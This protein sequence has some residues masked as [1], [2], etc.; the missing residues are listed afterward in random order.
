MCMI[1]SVG[2]AYAVN[3]QVNDSDV[4]S[5]EK[6][7]VR[8]AMIE[9][10][11]LSARPKWKEQVTAQI[12]SN[13]ASVACIWSKSTDFGV[14]RMHS[15]NVTVEFW[16]G[17]NE[18]TRLELRVRPREDGAV[19]GEEPID[20]AG[21]LAISR[22][23]VD[24]QLDGYWQSGEA[25]I[26]E[27]DAFYPRVR[28]RIVRGALPYASHQV[29]IQVDRFTGCVFSIAK[30]F[31]FFPRVAKGDGIVTSQ[32]ER[33][34]LRQI[35]LDAYNRYQPLDQASIKIAE[36]SYNIP[37][38]DRQ[39]NE[40]TEEHRQIMRDRK[41]MPV[42]RIGIEGVRSGRPLWVEVFVDAMTKRAMAITEMYLDDN[43]PHDGSGVPVPKAPTLEEFKL[44]AG[45]TLKLSREASPQ[46]QLT[47]D[48]TLLV[49]TKDHGLVLFSVDKSKKLL[50]VASKEPIVFKPSAESWRL[51][52][53]ELKHQPKA[54]FG[55]QK[56]Q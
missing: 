17:M 21:V 1:F 33:E 46:T 15:T 18:I 35:A 31:A 22:R 50:V 8:A 16:P 38:F 7:L 42:Y 34:F 10:V 23:V 19:E 20:D 43:L 41:V 29:R 4:T 55:K 44:L 12:E 56:N 47:V 5:A 36:V 45:A 26:D 27:Q 39:A 13:L 40:M 54:P 28:T 25:V 3:S 30:S 37:L 11:E 2:L 6:A 14:I 9:V 32:I 49:T 48:D 24:A 51:I 52:L 53:D